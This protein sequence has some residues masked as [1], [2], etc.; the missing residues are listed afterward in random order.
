MA[1]EQS[2]GIDTKDTAQTMSSKLRYLKQA[3]K[4]LETFLAT[5]RETDRGYGASRDMIS[6]KDYMSYRG[7]SEWASQPFVSDQ[8]LTQPA[9]KIDSHRRSEET[10]VAQ[11]LRSE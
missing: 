7:L 1:D 11:L 10:N 4:E 5:I 8:P 6:W 2:R 3:T 9:A